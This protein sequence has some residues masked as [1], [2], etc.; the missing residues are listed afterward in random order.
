MMITGNGITLYRWLAIRSA[1]ELE[2]RTGMKSR[3]FHAAKPNLC[4]ELGLSPRAR[5]TTML[6][7][8]ERRIP[9]VANQVKPGEI[10]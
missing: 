9:F 7:A 4:K 2:L 3:L 8:V 5:L 6:D 10:T 1:I